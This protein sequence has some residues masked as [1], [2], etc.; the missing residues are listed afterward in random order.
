MPI[1]SVRY[2]NSEERFEKIIPDFAL[3]LVGFFALIHIFTL[4]VAIGVIGKVNQPILMIMGA[5]FVFLGN[6]LPKV[7]SNFYLGIRTPWSLSSETV[8][9]KTHRLGGIC[10]IVSGFLMFVASLMGKYS[11]L[12]NQVFLGIVFIIILIPIVFSFAWYKQEKG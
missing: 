6:F 3:I 11:S 8:W 5:F 4:F 9:R 2:K 10:F 7:P 12:A 1:F